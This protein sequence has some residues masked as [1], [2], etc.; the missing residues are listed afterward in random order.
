M[1]HV[2]SLAG[3]INMTDAPITFIVPHTH[4]VP[5]TGWYLEAYPHVKDKARKGTFEI[6]VVEDDWIKVKDFRLKTLLTHEF[7]DNR[8]LH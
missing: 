2:Q 4:I 1:D 3:F 6:E 5:F 7:E 8:L